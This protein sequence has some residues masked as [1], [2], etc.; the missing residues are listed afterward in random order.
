MRQVAC[1]TNLAGGIC[2]NF[3]DPT[4]QPKGNLSNPP[5]VVERCFG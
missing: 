2:G 3:E 4:V 1:C 5:A